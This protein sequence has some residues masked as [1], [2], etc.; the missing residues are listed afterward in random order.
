MTIFMTKLLLEKFTK[1]F[2]LRNFYTKYFYRI[3]RLCLVFG[4]LK[5]SS[6][7]VNNNNMTLIDLMSMCGLLK[8]FGIVRLSL[9]YPMCLI[10]SR[11]M[12]LFVKLENHVN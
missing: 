10:V 8:I 9:H 12:F 2:F 6:R 5:V 4:I 3:H 1:I 7:L 11:H